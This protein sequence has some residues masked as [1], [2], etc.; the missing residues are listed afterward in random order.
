M[1]AVLGRCRCRDIHRF[2]VGLSHFWE[3]AIALH[4]AEHEFL[5]RPASLLQ[6]DK[7]VTES[8]GLL[9]EELARGFN[10]EK[11]VLA[12][13]DAEVERIFVWAVGRRSNQNGL[14]HRSA[15]L[16]APTCSCSIAFGASVCWNN[17]EGSGSGF[18]W[19]HQTGA[20]LAEVP[21][22]P[23][24]A[25]HRNSPCVPCSSPRSISRAV[26]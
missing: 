14:R 11:A 9:L 23:A 15:P 19:N 18:G 7:G 5:A 6:V 26:R 22:P 13:R 25:P 24:S 10:C 21:R 4:A 3:I 2:G 16:L 17:L 20:R 12:F 8:L 1:N